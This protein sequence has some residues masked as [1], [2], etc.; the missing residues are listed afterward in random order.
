M[1]AVLVL[2]ITHYLYS[3]E[4]CACQRLWYVRHLLYNTL[5]SYL[6][7]ITYFAV[8]NLQLHDEH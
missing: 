7:K 8:G 6:F 4:T 2:G 1:P 3:K 5:T